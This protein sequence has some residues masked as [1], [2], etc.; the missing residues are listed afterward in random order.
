M[1]QSL[2]TKINHHHQS[3]IDN[4]ES[5]IEINQSIIDNNESII[6]INQSIITMNQ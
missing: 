5:I 4:N 1:N 2:I 6:E 3:I